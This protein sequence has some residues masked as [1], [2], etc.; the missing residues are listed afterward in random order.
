MTEHNRLIRFASNLLSSKESGMRIGVL[1]ACLFG[2]SVAV[3]AEATSGAA[4]P[5]PGFMNFFWALLVSA[6]LSFG[7]AIA[8]RLTIG[9]MD[10]S[11]FGHV[12]R[13]GVVI[14]LALFACFTSFSLWSEFS[15][16]IMFSSVVPLAVAYFHTKYTVFYM[17]RSVVPKYS[18]HRLC[19]AAA[20][21]A[22]APVTLWL[23]HFCGVSDPSWV[24]VIFFW[25]IPAISALTLGVKCEL[26]NFELFAAGI[27]L[28][29]FAGAKRLFVE[30][31]NREHI[32]VIEAELE[33]RELDDAHRMTAYVLKDSDVDVKI[34][35][36]E[37]RLNYLVKTMLDYMVKC[38]CLV[39]HEKNGETYYVGFGSKGYL[40][41]LEKELEE[42]ERAEQERKVE[43][44]MEREKRK[45][46]LTGV[47]SEAVN[48][49]FVG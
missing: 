8:V 47:L 12:L 40:E 24:T 30:N 45:E 33:F 36:S 25:L 43:R 20:L 44:E 41:S 11:V 14:L 26:E 7:I 46:E 49:K 32:S 5:T 9:L 27:D 19:A 2:V 35:M 3:A 15:W 13:S 29:N 22:V 10:E 28:F 34:D 31:A 4:E 37:E 42:L 17:R 48:H 39:K 6:I 23:C 1:I 21:I 18:G 38:E 16:L